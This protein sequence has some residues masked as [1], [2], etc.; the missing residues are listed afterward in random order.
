MAHD[1]SPCKEGGIG[2]DAVTFS[3][4]SPS[5]AAGRVTLLSQSA[6]TTQLPLPSL[7]IKTSLEPLTAF[8]EALF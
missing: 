6:P 3:Y 8:I 4:T 7:A 2:M 5:A 1:Q